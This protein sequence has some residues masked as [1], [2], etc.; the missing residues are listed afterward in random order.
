MLKRWFG[1]RR[2]P[3]TL[4]V[5]GVVFLREQDGA[6]EQDLKQELVN[7]FQQRSDVNAAYLVT[8]SYQGR[9]E[10]S[11]ALCITGVPG[12]SRAEIANAVSTIF[13][14]MFVVQEHL[15]IMFPSG[16]QEAQLEQV[17]TPFFVRRSGPY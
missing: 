9:P 8:V 3:D 14:R 1:R 12:T 10:P 17:A 4:H 13:A 11:I 7:L 16:V 5:G 6:P 2:A 15:D